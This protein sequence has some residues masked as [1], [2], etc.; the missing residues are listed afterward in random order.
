MNIGI[1]GLG[2]VGGATNEVLKDF[3]NVFTYEHAHHY[4]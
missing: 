4:H 3:Y 1:V 2:Y